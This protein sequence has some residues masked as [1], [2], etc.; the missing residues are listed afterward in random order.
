[1][2]EKSDRKHIAKISP[3]F[4]GCALEVDMHRS[5]TT[6]NGT[7]SKI[8]FFFFLNLQSLGQGNWGFAGLILQ[9]MIA[10]VL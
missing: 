3:F 4:M 2:H 8:H 7:Y 5:V 1:M 10:A 6:H 9:G